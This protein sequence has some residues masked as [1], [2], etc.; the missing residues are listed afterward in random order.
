MLTVPP[1]Q[2]LLFRPAS[3][4]CLP[5]VCRTE[6][7]K[8]KGNVHKGRADEEGETVTT[9]T[10]QLSDVVGG[11]NASSAVFV[12]LPADAGIAIVPV[13]VAS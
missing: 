11:G 12:L 1:D 8:G 4:L 6:L 7:R 9:V 3:S 5:L 10:A 2:P 13:A